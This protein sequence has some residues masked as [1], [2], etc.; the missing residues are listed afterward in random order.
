MRRSRLWRIVSYIVSECPALFKF[1]DNN[2]RQTWYKTNT[3]CHQC[4]FSKVWQLFI[5][6]IIVCHI[7][8]T[9]NPAYQ[10]AWK[11]QNSTGQEIP[12]TWPE[13]WI[14]LRCIP[15][16]ITHNIFEVKGRKFRQWFWLIMN[17]FVGVS[18]RIFN[19]NNVLCQASTGKGVKT[20]HRKQ[21]TF[22]RLTLYS[23]F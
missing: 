19:N 9:S 17:C 10:D 6:R 7:R 22:Q 21:A 13:L 11:W 18:S 16:H 5:R 15:V 23:F 14:Q 12:F 8:K 3:A 2:Q 1:A 4:C 20:H